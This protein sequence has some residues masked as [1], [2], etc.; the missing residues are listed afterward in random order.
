MKQTPPSNLLANKVFVITGANS[1][2]GYETALGI[3]KTGAQVLIVGR[4][5]EKCQEAQNKIIA[6][7]Q[8]QQVNVLLADFSVQQSIRQFAEDFKRKYDRLDVLVNNAGAMFTTRKTTPD[9]HEQT[10]GLNHLGYFLTT[11]YLLDVIKNTPHARIV[12]VASE[13]HRIGQLNFDDLMY[14]KNSYSQWRAYGTSKLANILFTQH[15]AQLLNG[16]NVTTNSLHPGVVR[17]NFGNEH[18]IVRFA[19]Q[20]L[21][22]V[23]ITPKQGAK[24]SLFLSLEPLPAAHNGLYFDNCK[25]K[26]P[27]KAAQSPENAQQLWQNSLE[28]T[29]IET[30]GRV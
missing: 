13:A 3:A 27:S 2:I 23:G 21:P 9:G 12:N 17:T 14:Q 29:G 8:N 11:H 15:L 10:F 24:T 28:L 6:E 22:F 26:K 19:Y 4:S 16:Q 1:G 30:F 7:T 18:P 25:P 20:N 5:K